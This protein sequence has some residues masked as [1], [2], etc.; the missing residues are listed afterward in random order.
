MPLR[1]PRLAGVWSGAIAVL[2]TLGLQR[3]PRRTVQYDACGR[4]TNDRTSLPPCPQGPSSSACWR[5]A[6]E[7]LDVRELPELDPTLQHGT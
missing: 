5:A 2:H 1:R 4:G 3:I 6:G 7:L